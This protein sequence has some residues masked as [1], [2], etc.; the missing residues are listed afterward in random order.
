MNA[1]GIA[2]IFVADTVVLGAVAILIPRITRR[3]LLFGVYVGEAAHDAEAA[4]AIRRTWFL[5]MT[6]ATMACVVAALV[7]ATMP[8]DPMLAIVPELALLAI[9]VV[10]YV[11][12]YRGARDIARAPTGVPPPAPEIA[13]AHAG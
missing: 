10:L 4:R 1:H 2:W 6:A 11:R 5:G 8:V 7:L 13:V 3:G 9:G 12:A